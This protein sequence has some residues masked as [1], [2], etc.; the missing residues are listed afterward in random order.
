MSFL[1]DTRAQPSPTDT[2]SVWYLGAFTA[3][4]T[5]YLVV[6][7]ATGEGGLWASATAAAANV[8]PPAVI[9]LA[10]RPLLP[11]LRRLDR[12]RRLLAL[13]FGAILFSLSWYGL[14]AF[15]LGA[16]TVLQGRGFELIFLTG[17]GLVWQ[18]YQG[19]LVFALLLCATALHDAAP[20]PAERQPHAQTILVRTDEGLAPI[21]LSELLAIEA[22]DDASYIVLRN[23][24]LRT[25]TTLA[26]WSEQLDPTLFVRVHRSWIVNLKTVLSAEPIGGGR[27]IAHLPNGLSAP[28]SRSGARVLKGRAN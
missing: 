8:A 6:L 20:A 16:A 23:R 13:C 26:A 21:D 15:G 11:R 18:M 14:L 2:Y 3:L 7:M 25:N 9:G 19:L 10:A 1:T 5:A 28:V 22:D 4:Y 12:L 24:R 27:M 17:P